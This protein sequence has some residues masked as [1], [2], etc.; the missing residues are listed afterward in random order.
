MSAQSERPESPVR[1][2]LAGVAIVAAIVLGVVA[3]PPAVTFLR[4]KVLS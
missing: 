2:R 4:L 3:I 1:S